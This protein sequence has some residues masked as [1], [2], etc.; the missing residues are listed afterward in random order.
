[1][2]KY[3]HCV[4]CFSHIYDRNLSSRRIRDYDNLE[5]KQILDV[6]STF[7]MIDDGGLLCDAYNTTELGE[8]DCTRVSIMDKDSFPDWLEERKN[9]LESI[10][11]FGV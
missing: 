9:R 3:R 11:D 6:I 10:T 8:T 1:M 2:P 4:V 5:L 7:I